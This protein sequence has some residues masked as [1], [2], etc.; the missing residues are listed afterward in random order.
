MPGYTK[1]QDAGVVTLAV[2]PEPFKPLVS[3]RTAAIV[4][5]IF[6]LLNGFHIMTGL[7]VGGV[8]FGIL[9]YFGGAVVAHFP[10]AKL[11]R[12]PARISISRDWIEC[13]GRRTMRQDVQRIV[14]R[15][16]LDGS[17]DG[18][19]QTVVVGPVPTAAALGAAVRR[20]T[21]RVGF[22]VDIDVRGVPQT[23]AG[24]LTE[25]T[26]SGIVSEIIDVMRAPDVSDYRIGTP[27]ASVAR[28]DARL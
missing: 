6:V 26:A 13:D 14:V 28:P 8:V 17:D 21:A 16:H 27:D 3:T 15:N 18:G 22:R 7:I 11:H 5:G 9:W 4:G 10:S 19:G 1:T 20:K 24:G 25:P 2:E 12:K 23:L